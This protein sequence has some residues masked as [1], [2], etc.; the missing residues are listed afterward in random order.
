[1]YLYSACIFCAFLGP[2]FNILFPRHNILSYRYYCSVLRLL[3]LIKRPFGFPLIQNN[4]ISASITRQCAKRKCIIYVIR[5]FYTR[6][7]IYFYFQCFTDDSKTLWYYN[8]FHVNIISHIIDEGS[9]IV[10][11]SVISKLILLLGIY[12][13]TDHY[14]TRTLTRL[15]P[16]ITVEKN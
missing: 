11:A 14:N 7:H 16:R 3:R 15:Q 2:L 10:V 1:M 8:P 6:V 13:R 4:I 12:T 5:D 9:Y